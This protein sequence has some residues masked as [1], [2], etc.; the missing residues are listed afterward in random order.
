M[1]RFCCALL[2]V[3]LA[4]LGLTAAAVHAAPLPF[5]GTLTF[6]IAHLPELV[7]SGSGVAVVNGSGGGG[8]LDS[9]AL[10][11]GAFETTALTAPLIVATPSLTRGIQVTVSNES[12][13]VGSAGG[14]L[15][16]V[17]PLKGLL[18][19]CLKTGQGCTSP[20]FNIS[21]PL[22]VVGSGGTQSASFYVNST[23][24][25]APWTTGVASAFGETAQGFAH[26]PASATSSTAAPGGVVSLVTPI[27]LSTNIGAY[28]V[29]PGF[30]RLTLQFVPEPASAALLFGGF[31]VLGIAA[32]RR[33]ARH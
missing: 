9:L 18:R 12:G 14:S 11:S 33:S 21:V 20:F 13:M 19:I 8:H 23:V 26:G 25:G 16:G 5:S 27:R 22:T 2:L 1:S 10:P 29:V 4:H 30:A 17:L 15:G 32:R 28:A 3:V 7:V 6:Q 31:A 24:E